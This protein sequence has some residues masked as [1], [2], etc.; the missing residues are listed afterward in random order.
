MRPPQHSFSNNLYICVQY[1]R[2]SISYIISV[3]VLKSHF[4]RKINFFL[5]YSGMCCCLIFSG[6]PLNRVELKN[7]TFRNCSHRQRV[8]FLYKNSEFK[9]VHFYYCYYYFPQLRQ[10]SSTLRLGGSN[11]QSMNSPLYRRQH[12]NIFIKTS[13][14][15]F[16]Q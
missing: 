11:K 15:T 2:Y 7:S 1:M 14:Y 6:T 5:N 12:K 9:V 3:K 4:M 10:F 8:F 13:Y 16:L